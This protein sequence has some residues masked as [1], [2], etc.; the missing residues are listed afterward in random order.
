MDIK[1]DNIIVNLNL[2]DI[3]LKDMI[4]LRHKTSTK[5]TI[6]LQNLSINLCFAL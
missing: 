1:I 5:Y 4:H 3:Y 6:V 2:I